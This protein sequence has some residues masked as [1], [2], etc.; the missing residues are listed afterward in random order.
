MRNQPQKEKWEKKALYDTI[1]QIDI[2]DIYRTFH[3]KT[4]DYSFFS[5]AHGTFTKV[6]HTFSHKIICTNIKGF[7]YD[8]VHFLITMEINQI[9]ITKKIGKILKHLKIKIY[10]SKRES[11]GK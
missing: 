6:D 9:S 10:R 4:A 3:P 2:I 8:K 1:D 7:K 5:S 11:E